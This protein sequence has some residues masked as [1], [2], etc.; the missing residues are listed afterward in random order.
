LRRFEK[1]TVRETIVGVRSSDVQWLQ[2]L[3]NAGPKAA[4][5]AQA[6]LAQLWR[7]MFGSLLVPLL[8]GNLYVTE[9]GTEGNRTF[10]Y[11]RAVWRR[12][13]AA[14]RRTKLS[15]DYAVIGNDVAGERM[16][17]R[18][19]GYSYA[20]L[21]PKSGGRVR[22]IANLGRRPTPAEAIACGQRPDFA[23][24]INAALAPLHRVLQFETRQRLLLSVVTCCCWL[25][26]FNSVSNFLMFRPELLGAS[27]FHWDDIYVRMVPFVKQWR[28]AGSPTLAAA[29]VDAQSSFDRISQEALEPAV[30]SLLRRSRY[31]VAR[32]Q[33]LAPNAHTGRLMM[34]FVRA[35][36]PP[37]AA[38][39]DAIALARSRA[40]AAAHAVLA[41]VVRIARHSR[42][43]HCLALSL[44]L[45]RRCVAARSRI[46][47]QRTIVG[48]TRTHL[49]QLHS[50]NY[51]I[52]AICVC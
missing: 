12:V 8:A 15:S 47:T 26:L 9:S 27:V 16:L 4:G 52:V 22:A 1:M 31:T 48:T 34:R 36:P 21:L 46:G 20:R 41:D 2:T 33:T 51:T 30:A 28:A 19:F 10:Y 29:C 44:H 13:V 5:A 14:W 50:S 40:A 43:C 7:W 24:S 25:V 49:S 42:R 18:G 32:W 35:V 6:R 23:S 38:A 39:A 37:R 3:H 11:R 45:A 17:Q